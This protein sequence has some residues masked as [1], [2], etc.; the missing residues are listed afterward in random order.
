[1]C[2]NVYF[3]AKIAG[4]FVHHICTLLE[5]KLGTGGETFIE[6]NTTESSHYLC[7]TQESS[8]Q[9]SYYGNSNSKV[10]AFSHSF[11]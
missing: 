2:F 1:M 9:S 6:D 10:R 3:F 8:L 5:R 4:N 7:D 11:V